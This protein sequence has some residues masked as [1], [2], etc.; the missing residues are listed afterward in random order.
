MK[1][2][3]EEFESQKYPNNLVY[4]FK[5]YKK[6]GQTKLSSIHAVKPSSLINSFE[7]KMEYKE[8]EKLIEEPP[9]TKKKLQIAF[10]IFNKNKEYS[11]IEI[12]NEETGEIIDYIEEGTPIFENKKRKKLI[13]K[14]KKETEEFESQKYPNN[15]VY[16]FKFYNKKGQ[17]KLSSIHAVNP[18]SLIHS[19]ES[20]MDLKEYEKLI[21]EKTSTKEILQIAL[22]IFNKNNKYSRIEIINEETGEIIDFIESTT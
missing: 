8:Y 18:S 20:I 2:E 17:T 9:S 10:K 14:M 19:F 3:T 21:E 7:N 15:L 22:K 6:N 1:K 5:F 13:E 16:C 12:I 4:C 11:R